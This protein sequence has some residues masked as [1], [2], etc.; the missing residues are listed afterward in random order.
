[1]VSPSSMGEGMSVKS[2]VTPTG[3]VAI[4]VQLDWEVMLLKT[5]TEW[6]PLATVLIVHSPPENVQVVTFPGAIG[7]G[8]LRS[9]P[10]RWW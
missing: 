5:Q 8:V 4:F 2:I 10:S 6:P 7:A 9:P 3:W 1:M